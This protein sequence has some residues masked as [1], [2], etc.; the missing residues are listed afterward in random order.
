MKRETL[1]HPKTFAL[2]HLLG[3]SR[4]EAL[5]YLTILWDYT[6]DIAIQGDI[7]KW[8]NAVIAQA[9]DWN[10][11]PDEFVGSLIESGWLDEVDSPARL[12]IHDWPAH[13]EN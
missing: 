6:G 3:C 7:G 12:I 11:D 2:M 4:P 9:C 8:P 13:C 10:G 1:R 5:G